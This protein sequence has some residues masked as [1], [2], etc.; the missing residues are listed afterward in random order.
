MTAFLYFV[1]VA[2]AYA[3]AMVFLGRFLRS[4]GY[5]SKLDAL[6]NWHQRMQVRIRASIRGR[7]SKGRAV[8]ASNTD[9]Q[10]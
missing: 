9:D 1:L 7:R 4:R 2:V 6:R 8:Q 5:G 10:S 3:A